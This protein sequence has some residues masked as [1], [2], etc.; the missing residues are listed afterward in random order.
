MSRRIQ[1]TPGS[2]PIYDNQDALVVGE[3][4]KTATVV[5]AQLPW[6]AII[7]TP[8][9]EMTATAG[10]YLAQHQDGH[11]WPIKR[12]TFESTYEVCS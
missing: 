7:V 3:Y 8:E 2:F 11:A 10:D 12:E 6:D 5:A 9:G 4:R 1:G